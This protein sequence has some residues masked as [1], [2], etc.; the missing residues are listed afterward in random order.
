MV[1]YFSAKEVYT[2]SIPVLVSLGIRQ[3]RY[4]MGAGMN[5]GRMRM[6][7]SDSYASTGESLC[8]R[9]TNWIESGQA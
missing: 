7:Q 9:W 3:S 5:S 4:L 2:G 1:R 6:Q 8:R